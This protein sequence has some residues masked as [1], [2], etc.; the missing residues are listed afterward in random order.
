VQAFVYVW[1]VESLDTFDNHFSNY[2]RFSNSR[3][4][5]GWIT[6]ITLIY[7]SIDSMREIGSS[8][9]GTSNA[10][11]KHLLDSFNEGRRHAQFPPKSFQRENSFFRGKKQNHD[12]D[13]NRNLYTVQEN[14]ASLV[15]STNIMGEFSKCTVISR[16]IPENMYPGL[17]EKANT[18]RAVFISLPSRAKCLTFVLFLG[19]ICNGMAI[20]YENILRELTKTIGLDEVIADTQT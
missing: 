19:A 2:S 7:W 5:D 6:S 11:E 17:V 4:T 1:H 18:I 12:G 13:S 16:L 20:Q 15:I 8:D 10:D 14:A 9:S 3:G